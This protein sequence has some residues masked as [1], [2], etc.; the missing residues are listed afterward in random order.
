MRL[1]DK[2]ML[3]YMNAF[4]DAVKTSGQLNAISRKWLLADLPE[5]PA[6][7]EGIPY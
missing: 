1:N 5:F 2:A 3:D 4:V 6:K 7:M